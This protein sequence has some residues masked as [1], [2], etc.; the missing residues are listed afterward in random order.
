MA[1]S[2][3]LNSSAFMRVLWAHTLYISSLGQNILL[4]LLAA[5]EALLIVAKKDFAITL[6]YGSILSS[7]FAHVFLGS[8]PIICI[9]GST[10]TLLP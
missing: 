1:T 10:E 4:V 2:K 6:Q 8:K 9:L 3:L 5:M 7:Y